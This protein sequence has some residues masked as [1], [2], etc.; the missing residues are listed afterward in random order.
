M[1]WFGKK[2]GQE[3]V[4]AVAGETS[5]VAAKTPENDRNQCIEYLKSILSADGR[6]SRGVV[7]KL[8]I[9]NF[10]RLNQLF[11]Y[12]YCENLLRQIIS[13]LTEA[14]GVAVYRYIGVEFIMVF[15]ES[16][17]GPV[18]ELCERL[19]ER[20]NHVWKINQTECLCSVQMGIC[21]Y[22]GNARTV[23]DILKYLD[24]A[25]LKA[26]EYGPNQTA[27]YDGT[28]HAQLVRRQSIASYL[29]AA[30]E[31]R[32]V[33]VRFRPTYH[34][35]KKRFVR[36]ELYMRIFVKG[37]G[38][39]GSAEFLPVAEDSGQI[40]MLECFALDHVGA[41]IAGLMEQGTEFE[42]ISTRISPVAFLHED[43]IEE[44]QQVIDRY[45]IPRGKMAIEITENI[46]TTAYLDVN[47]ML[48][49]LSG[50][51]VEIILNDF[52]SGYS[53]VASILELPVE[54]VKFERMFIWQIEGN[55]KASV[56]IDGLV[57]LAD[58]L[59]L[60]MIAEGVETERQ[61]DVLN[62][63]GCIYQQGYYY[64]PTIGWE[65]LRRVMNKSMEASAGILAEEKEKMR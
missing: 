64:S 39:I 30:I 43:F 3:P 13:Y 29:N 36:A 62:G 21:S 24:L 37:L 17:V 41:C 7:L 49:R 47:I 27:V 16:A 12:D 61:L 22:P 55:P 2:A 1:A 56:L 26:M 8:H 54:T 23:D 60:K 59:G 33:E 42:S 52:G 31:N 18:T 11:S 46:F 34:I 20:F 48:Q 38:M 40:W 15:E 50:M 32:E 4:K 51:G 63:A 65:A 25:V 5:A 57:K 10:K 28:L 14:A 58:N 53:S 19:S 35:E 6:P 44:V 45:R 9:D